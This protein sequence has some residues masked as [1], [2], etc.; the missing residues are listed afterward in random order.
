MKAAHRNLT[1]LIGIG[2]LLWALHGCFDP[3]PPAGVLCAQDG[4]C[5]PPQVCDQQIWMCVGNA[6]QITDAGWWSIPDAVEPPWWIPDAGVPL[7]VPDAM[8]T[9]QGIESARAAPDG[10]TYIEISR[11]LITYVKPAVDNE[12]AGFFVQRDAAGP[13][14]LV[15]V[16]P[17]ALGAPL[18]AGDRVSFTALEMDTY[19]AMRA[20]TAL[21]EIVVHS[22]GNEI[23][24]LVQDISGETELLYELASYEGELVSVRFEVVGL[25]SPDD[26]GFMA[27]QIATSGISDSSMF[28]LRV[29][30][31]VQALAGLEPGCEVS[32][33]ATPLWR[34][35]VTAKVTAWRFDELQLVLCPAP[36]VESV[37]AASNTE[38][39]IELNRAVDLDTVLPDGSQ[40][41]FD[42]G[43]LATAASASERYVTVTTTPQTPGLLYTVTVAG[44]VVDVFAGAVDHRYDEGSFEGAPAFTPARNR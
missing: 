34:T 23:L 30:T 24:G 8:S 22:R 27:S 15:A 21:G 40:F 43:L 28:R 38:V 16:D 44:S 19:G 41:T 12:P 26:E 14:L 7:P 25:M 33:V 5:P 4:W 32:L 37:T 1:G 10:P 35:S 29:P 20:V 9:L 31:T 11:A 2:S 17:A 6:S 39:R 42:N 3:S 36:R 13:A 18:A